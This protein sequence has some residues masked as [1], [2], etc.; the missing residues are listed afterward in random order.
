MASKVLFA[1]GCVLM[2]ACSSSNFGG[3]STSNKDSTQDGQTAVAASKTETSAD[4]ASQQDTDVTS[5]P[6][7]VGG[8][9][10]VCEKTADIDCVLNNKDGSKF[11]FAKQVST[12]STVDLFSGPTAQV[13]SLAWQSANSPWH[14]KLIPQNFAVAD[15]SKLKLHIAGQA[16]RQSDFE[17]SFS[18][19]PIR[20]GDGGLGIYQVGCSQETLQ[21]AKQTSP[22]YSQDVLLGDGQDKIVV[23]LQR[24]CGV[25]MAD[26]DSISLRRG[27][28][29]VKEDFLPV[30]P[31]ETNQTFT[32]DGLS[33]GQ[34]TVVLTSRKVG[35]EYDDFLF[36]DMVISH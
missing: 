6:I 12:T 17:A 24:F 25:L 33:A 8:A 32:F 19:T 20:V 28:A 4:V 34:Y 15:V 18:Q 31:T 14:W 22:V 29:T 2:A 7:S 36:Y 21:K 23:G 5:E 27:G 16:D 26:N 9:F 30:L 3:S 10:L 1:V 13:A 35:L 11:N